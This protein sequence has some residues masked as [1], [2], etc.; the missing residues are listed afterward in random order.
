MRF[1]IRMYKEFAVLL[2]VLTIYTATLWYLAKSSFETQCEQLDHNQWSQPTDATAVSN[3]LPETANILNNVLLVM[4]ISTPENR[5]R[6]DVI[7]KTWVG[8][9]VQHKKK[10]AVKFVIG[11]FD[12]NASKTESLISE[13]KTFGDLLLLTNHLDSYNNLTRKVLHTFVWV[14]KNTDY[15][16]V[17]KIDEDS[18]PKLDRIELE[19]KERT[20]R[21]PLYWGLVASQGTPKKEGKW[22]EPNWKLC[23]KYLPY[24]LGGGYVLSKY[25]IHRIAI[26]ADGLTL[27]NNEDVS[28]GAWISPFNL[29]R[30]ND[31]R[32]RSDMQKNWHHDQCKDYLLVHH[33]SIEDA[34][35][36]H[37]IMKSKGVLC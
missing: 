2:L 4:V 29:E 26:N 31:K 8:S 3:D 10:F 16:F 7:R 20:N 35:K 25:L 5:A 9:Y 24:A 32:F 33:L 15:S 30:K 22:A 28:V 21:K 6:K 14:D 23:D 34:E 13:N 18:F 37:E 27:Y 12:L 1:V 17:L 19:L 11:T 36:T